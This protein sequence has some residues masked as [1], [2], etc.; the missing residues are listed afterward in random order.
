MVYQ[1]SL[2]RNHCFHRMTP[3]K[4]ILQSEFLSIKPNSKATN[5]IS[6]MNQDHPTQQIIS[7]STKNRPQGNSPLSI[8]R[9]Q[10]SSLMQSLHQTYLTRTSEEIEKATATDPT[11]Q[12]L[13]SAIIRGYISTREQNQLTSY[14]E[15]IVR[16]ELKQQHHTERS[17]HRHSRNSEK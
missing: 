16:A 14:K 3:A 5:L 12:G 4:K 6:S 10:N 13:S 17:H 7:H 1:T 8:P 2:I 15:N 9:K 11:M